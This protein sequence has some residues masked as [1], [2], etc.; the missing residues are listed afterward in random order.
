MGTMSSGLNAKTL[1]LPPDAGRADL[2]PPGMALGLRAQER[3]GLRS[4]PA[5]NTP[6][7][8]LQTPLHAC[9][10]APP[11]SP[12]SLQ[13]LERAHHRSR[14]RMVTLFVAIAGL[15]VG[16]AWALGGGALTVVAL[17]LVL[18]GFGGICHLPAPVVM[19][20]RRAIP[21]IPASHNDD[22][23]PVSKRE[24]RPASS[25]TR[26]QERGGTHPA[27]EGCLDLDTSRPDGPTAS[28]RLDLAATVSSLAAR[29]GLRH[30][31]TLYRLP[32]HGINALAAGCTDHTAIALS[33]ESLNALSAREIRAVL[34]HEIAH[35]EAGDTRLFALT[36]LITELTRGAAQLSLFSGLAISLASGA[37]PLSWFQTLLFIVAAPLASLLRLALAHNQEFAADLN[38]VRLTE[39]PLGLIAALRRIDGG[40]QPP[41]ALIL[42][43]T[44]PPSDHPSPRQRIARLSH[45]CFQ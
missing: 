18:I 23:P 26:S 43:G 14:R 1:G 30:A 9:E 7:S 16:C 22:A 6:P 12:P 4:R 35:L 29:A 34:A 13:R 33:N 41:P 3:T 40:K 20:R 44:P 45:H 24:Q 5:P 17:A 2:R 27:S 32:G 31:P 39:D 38:A 8:S 10:R 11:L 25:W 36:H 21:L 15:L 37:S 42:P 28:A 19:I